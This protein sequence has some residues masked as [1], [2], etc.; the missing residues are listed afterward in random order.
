MESFV[1][2]IIKM[3]SEWN[4]SRET[5]R[6]DETLR[7]VLSTFASKTSM[8]GVARFRSSRGKISN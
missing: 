6:K 3:E 7:G 8:H 4:H 5:S 2:N 1:W